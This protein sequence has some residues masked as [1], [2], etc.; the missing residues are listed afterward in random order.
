MEQEDLDTALL[1]A[2]AANDASELIRL[3]TMAGDRSE[4]RQDVDAA[5]FY[6]THAFVFALEA[7]APEARDLNKRLADQG[8]AKL[9]EF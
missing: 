6:L 2:H 3:Y 7:G 9:L 8:R 5:C 1:A 4:Q